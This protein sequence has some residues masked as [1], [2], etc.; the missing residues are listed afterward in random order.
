MSFAL[1]FSITNCTRLL[2]NIRRAY[3]LGNESTQATQHSTFATVS[4]VHMPPTFT[5]GVRQEDSFDLEHCGEIEVEVRVEVT[6]TVENY[7]LAD[8]TSS[9][10]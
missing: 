2:L 6:R 1:A 3:Y 4:G 10:L 9:S 8:L 7:E 5:R